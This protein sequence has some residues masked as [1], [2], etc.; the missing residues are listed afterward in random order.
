[1]PPEPINAGINVNGQSATQPQFVDAMRT[2]ESVFCSQRF[3]E[4]LRD[5]CRSRIS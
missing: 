1:M 3:F 2:S 4:L 5:L